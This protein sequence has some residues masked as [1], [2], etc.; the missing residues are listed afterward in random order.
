MNNIVEKMDKFVESKRFKRII[1][2][3]GIIFILFLVFQAGMITGFKKASF[4]RNWGDNYERNFGPK[5]RTPR[6]LRDN[7]SILPNAH[8]AIGKIIKID[9]PNIVVLD[10][11]QTE[12][13]IIIN[14]NTSI[15]E[16]RDKVGK[17]SLVLDKYVIV[18]GAPNELGQIESKLVRIIPSPEAMT[19]KDLPE[20]KDGM[21]RESGVLKI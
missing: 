18:I 20:M 15:I 8:G 2:I 7:L 9:F 5:D 3:L 19:S 1:Y 21:M 6:L 14:D 17:E 12:K 16:R 13:V 11:D 10:K 4:G